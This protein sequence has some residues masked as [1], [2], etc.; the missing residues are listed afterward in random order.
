VLSLCQTVGMGPKPGVRAAHRARM[1]REILAVGE[2]H[3]AR[4]GAA[5][6]SLRAIA[7]ELGVASS[8]VYRYVESRDE[9]L[10]RLIIA[11]YDALGDAVDAALAGVEDPRERFAVIGRT[12]RA[13]ARAHPEQ[14]A[15]VYGSPVPGYAAPAERTNEA[16]TRLTR[17][18]LDALQR[19]PHVPGLDV[20]RLDVRPDTYGEPADLPADLP[21]PA[22]TLGLAAWS[23]V[24]GSVT[25]EV[26]EQFGPQTVMDWEA[27]F[28]AVLVAA[29]ALVS[30]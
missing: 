10:T 16:G 20:A 14:F 18:L 26:F 28:E 23:M 29:L 17:H 22:L 25:A 9:L 21:L 2:R 15:L 12:L 5:A 24:M 13:W 4:D 19:M 1:E 6:L 11:A 27:H 7:R 8:A 30:G 3:L